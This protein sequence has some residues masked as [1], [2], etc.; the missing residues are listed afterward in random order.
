MTTGQR[1]RKGS[2]SDII[3]E[4]FTTLMILTQ[5]L[6]KIQ[7]STWRNNTACHKLTSSLLICQLI[8]RCVN[9]SNE[10][11]FFDVKHVPGSRVI[12]EITHY[13]GFNF[14]LLTTSQLP[15]DLGTPPPPPENT[16]AFC[17]SF[18][19]R[20]VRN[21]GFLTCYR[22]YRIIQYKAMLVPSVAASVSCEELHKV[23]ICWCSIHSLMIKISLRIHRPFSEGYVA[24]LGVTRFHPNDNIFSCALY[25]L[26][27]PFFSNEV[28]YCPRDAK[29]PSVIN[30]T[31]YFF[32]FYEFAIVFACIVFA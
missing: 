16:L 30:Q 7:T 22:I 10:P 17:V 29:R 2:L 8:G 24:L 20:T 25:L 1:L 15:S 9:L 4:N 31:A 6:V 32:R 5:V 12:A 26:G 14:K 23:I 27:H 28:W 18:R 3:A 21:L 11:T 19:N 13:S